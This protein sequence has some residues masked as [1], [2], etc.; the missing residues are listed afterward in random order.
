MSK[1]VRHDGGVKAILRSVVSGSFPKFVAAV[2]LKTVPQVADNHLQIPLFHF[3][4]GVP[5]AVLHA[6]V[7]SSLA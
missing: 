4:S 6:R 1:N 3:A 5:P 7:K 2:A